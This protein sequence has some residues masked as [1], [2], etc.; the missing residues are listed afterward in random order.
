MAQ[1]QVRSWRDRIG[2]NDEWHAAIQLLKDF[3]VTGSPYTT[4]DLTVEQHSYLQ[5][6]LHLDGIR[7]DAWCVACGRDATFSVGPFFD[8]AKGAG[9]RKSANELAQTNSRGTITPE[10][11]EPA[12]I[13]AHLVS[14]CARENHHPLTFAIDVAYIWVE[15]N[16][17]IVRLTKFG[18]LPA[19]ADM[20]QR[21]V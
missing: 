21:E 6:A 10:V 1:I 8:A 14:T 15:S 3:L 4:L 18:Q 19:M 11:Q 16:D 17:V 20:A 12:E 13:S 5:E 7:F 2:L 9:F